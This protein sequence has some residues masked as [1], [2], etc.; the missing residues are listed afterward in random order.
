[1]GY[2]YHRPTSLEEALALASEIPGARFIAG[3]TDLLVQESNGRLAAPTLISLRR[4]P[5]LGGISVA[6][7]IRIGAA[8]PLA[9]VAAHPEI[10]STYPA[11]VESIRVLGSPQIRNVATLGGNLCNA[12]PAADTA[13]ALLI[14]GATVEIRGLETTRE[15]PLE[16]FFVG[17]GE[18]ALRP[19]EVLTAVWLDP[20][21]EGTRSV[22]LR[23]GRVAMDLAIV[24]VAASARRDD[25]SYT[26]VRLAA[27]AVAPTPVRLR[28]SEGVAEG[29]DLDAEVRAEAAR[30]AREEISPISD[31]RS[32]ASYR[33]HLTGVF[34]ER[35]LAAVAE[36]NPR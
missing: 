31:L 25:T 3:G 9:D 29:T 15:L 36:E 21:P 10:V 35:A 24:S 18:T 4:L 16:E 8:A 23:K 6:D 17:P 19:G 13:P 11:L 30:I 2:D 14:Y 22:F 33:T 28:R 20:P 26:G 5:E 34:V 32:S 7:R 12:S 27:G 1:M